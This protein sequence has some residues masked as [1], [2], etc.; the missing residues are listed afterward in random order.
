MRDD[1]RV[2]LHLN[3]RNVADV[4]PALSAILQRFSASSVATS[5][6]VATCVWIHHLRE[7]RYSNSIVLSLTTVEVFSLNPLHHTATA[8]LVSPRFTCIANSLGERFELR[9]NDKTHARAWLH[10]D[11]I[12][13]DV[14]RTKQLLVHSQSYSM[15]KPKIREQD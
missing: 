1:D 12:D 3:H 4:V 11:E 8:H 14:T 7:K 13:C 10:V 5:Q 9:M 15:H 2:D 6:R